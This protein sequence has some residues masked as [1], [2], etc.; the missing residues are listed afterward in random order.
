MPLSHHMWEAIFPY[1]FD[2]DDLNQIENPD[3]WDF[4][5]FDNMGKTLRRISC[6]KNIYVLHPEVISLKGFI[7][8]LRA[9]I[10]RIIS[11]FL[12]RNNTNRF[13]SLKLFCSEGLSHLD[14]NFVSFIWVSRDINWVFPFTS[15]E[16]LFHQL[17]N[18][19]L[20]LH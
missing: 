6:T 17:S 7:G 13:K 19:F 9:S 20:F 1:L 2:N 16:R 15:E 5:V 14:F 8:K 18:F 12:Q 3:S 10:L 4:K 11:N